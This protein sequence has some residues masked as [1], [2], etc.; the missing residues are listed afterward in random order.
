VLK[1]PVVLKIDG[2][3]GRLGPESFGWREKAAARGL[4]IF[5]GLQNATAVHQ[6]CDALFGLLQESCHE[7]ITDIVSERVGTRAT[8][9]REAKRATT[10]GK[11]VV[12]TKERQKVRHCRAWYFRV[13]TASQ[14]WLLT[15]FIAPR[16]Q[17][18]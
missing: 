13:R 16:V 4:L 8:Q 5:P 7:V 12:P 9:D 17:G 2:G 14:F 1:G 18:K 15:L 3:P 10:A 11:P 6:E